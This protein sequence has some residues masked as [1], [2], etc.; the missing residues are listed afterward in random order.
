M[1]MIVTIYLL[2]IQVFLAFEHITTDIFAFLAFMTAFISLIP[3]MEML[4]G[5]KFMED[6]PEAPDYPIDAGF[7]GMAIII[8]FFG[9]AGSIC[10]WYQF[11]HN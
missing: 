8:T 9:I 11:F 2:F 5:R 10:G 6:M 3:L 4:T 1:L 7:I